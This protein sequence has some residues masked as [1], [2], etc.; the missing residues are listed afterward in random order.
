MR[1]CRKIEGIHFMEVT[2]NM[3]VGNARL[4]P[5]AIRGEGGEHDP[6]LVIPIKIELYPQP[7]EHRI[8]IMRLSASLKC[9]EAVGQNNQFASTIHYDTTYNMQLR[10]VNYGPNESTPELHFNLTHARLKALE[11][12]RH[13]QAKPFT[14]AYNRSSSRMSTRSAATGQ[15]T[16]VV[17]EWSRLTGISSRVAVFWISAI[18][19]LRLNLAEMRWAEQIFPGMG[20]DTFRLIEV[21]LPA[22]NAIVPGEAIDYFKE[23]KTAYDGRDHRGSLEKSRYALDEVEKHITPRPQGHALGMAITTALGWSSTPDLTEQA[24]FLNSAWVGLY[25]LANA[26]HY[27]PSRK[28]LLPTDAHMVLIQLAAMLEYLGQIE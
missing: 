18:G 5:I 21:R 6:R 3:T 22:S 19:M 2:S 27:T 28:S 11:N 24:K 23:A 13:E 4:D 16:S 7:K 10:S 8:A 9:S 12:M 17:D 25:S 1:A 26:A 15:A 14:C 20:Y